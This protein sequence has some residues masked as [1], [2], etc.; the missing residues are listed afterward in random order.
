[1]HISSGEKRGMGDVELVPFGLQGRAACRGLVLSSLAQVSVVP[2]N[3]SKIT[4][5][6]LHDVKGRKENFNE[7]TA[8]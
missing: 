4:N 1:M 6:M 2:V 5:A 8:L 7:M 3:E